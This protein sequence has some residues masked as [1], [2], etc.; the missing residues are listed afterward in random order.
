VTEPTLSQHQIN[1]RHLLGAS[2]GLGLGG[3]LLRGGVK[4][5][6]AAPAD[7]SHLVWVWQFSADAPP[8][9]IGGKLREHGLGILLKTHDG[10]EWM[11]KYDKSPFAVSGPAQ[12]K[13]LANYY[14]SAGVPFHAW[15]VVTAEDPMREARM[16]A[17]VLDAG[18]RSL[19]LD[20][21]PH[22]G[23][24]RGTAADALTYGR[25][26]RRLQPNAQIV[27]SIDPRPWMLPKMPLREFASFSNAIAPQQYWRTFN[28]QANYDRFF[29]SGYPVPPG[30]VTPEFLLAVGKAALGGL[31]LPMIQVGQGATPDRDEWRRFMDASMGG[32]SNVVSVWRYGVT[33]ADVFQMLRDLPPR[34]PQA[35]PQVQIVAAGGTYVVKA[36]DSLSGIAAAHGVTVDQVMQANGMDNPN[37]LSVGQSL[38]IP[39]GAVAGTAV[40]TTVDASAGGGTAGSKVY[41]VQDGDTVSAIAGR[42]GTTVDAIAQLNGLNDPTM[43]SIGQELQ[44]PA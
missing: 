35:Q 13:V 44:V 29:E 30:G 16:A 22:S 31:G 37:Y 43:I 25:E 9:K 26:L 34:K 5:A 2:L 38:K 17:E 6:Q 41:V 40:S 1:R 21:E 4:S 28:T 20:I 24:W 33:S 11:S 8:E 36:G 27:L 10:V 32:G 3:L 15:A 19:F 23:F 42:F 12:T 14:E 7:L 18:A 39:G